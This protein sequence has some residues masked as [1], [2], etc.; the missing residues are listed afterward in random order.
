M[1]QKLEMMQNELVMAYFGT[2]GIRNM[3]INHWSAVFGISNNEEKNLDGY[4]YVKT[5]HIFIARKLNYC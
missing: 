4:S 2:S 5:L 1:N 3:S